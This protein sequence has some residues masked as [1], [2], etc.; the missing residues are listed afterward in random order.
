[1]QIDDIARAMSKDK[2]MKLCICIQ[3]RRN[4]NYGRRKSLEKMMIMWMAK[5]LD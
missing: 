3:E 5:T 4:K 2:N 1:M